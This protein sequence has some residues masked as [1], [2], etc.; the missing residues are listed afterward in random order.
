MSM[1]IST[2]PNAIAFATRAIG[3]RDMARCGTLV[4][5]AGLVVTMAFLALFR[6]MLS[7]L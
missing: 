2:P 6:T 1:P 5:L 7:A 3:T 4:S